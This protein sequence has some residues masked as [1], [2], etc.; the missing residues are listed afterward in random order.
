MGERAAERCSARLPLKPPETRDGRLNN[1]KSYL[2]RRWEE[3][4]G[5]RIRHPPPDHSSVYRCYR[6]AQLTQR[7]HASFIVSE[8]D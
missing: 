2:T 7:A 4:D 1:F 3:R 8:F 5:P 6:C